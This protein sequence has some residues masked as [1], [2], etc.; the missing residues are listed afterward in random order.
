MH[1]GHTAIDQ[2]MQNIV[3]VVL[4]KYLHSTKIANYKGFSY[5]SFK[6]AF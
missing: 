4:K 6:L 1:A 5:F 3:N 2:G